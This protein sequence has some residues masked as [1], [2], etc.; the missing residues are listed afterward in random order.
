MKRRLNRNYTRPSE[1]DRWEREAGIPG[2]TLGERLRVGI[3]VSDFCLYLEAGGKQNLHMAY[4]LYRK[5]SAPM[6][7]IWE[8]EAGRTGNSKPFQKCLK[9]LEAAQ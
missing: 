6:R 8:D 1:R 5:Q 4:V 9:L 2:M 3:D 7:R